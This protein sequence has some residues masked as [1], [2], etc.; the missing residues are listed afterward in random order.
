MKVV[1]LGT[2]AFA[3]P[4]LQRLLDSEHTVIAVVTQPDRPRGRGQRVRESAVKELARARGLPVLQPHRATDRVFLAEMTALAPDVGVVA[5]YGKLLPDDL[6]AI[7]HHGMINVHASLLPSYRG[8]API[9][10]AVLAGE[11]ETG[12]T[13][14]RLVHEMDAGPMLGRLA[15]PIGPDETSDAV[16]R[17]LATLGA[18]ALMRVVD[19]LAAGR[20]SEEE[21]DHRLATRAPRLTKADGIIDWTES[22]AA[23]HNRIRGLHPWPHASS[24]LN[25]RRYVILRSRTGGRPEIG[26][27]ASPPAAGEVLAAARDRLVVATGDDGALDILEI[28]PEGR[29]PQPVRDFLAGHV[30]VAGDVFGPGRS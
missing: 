3:V 26:P 22:S 6:L 5:A 23:V 19:D 28:Q 8:A 27:D 7:P 18:A 21:Q 2:P 12:V 30:L 15:R 16:E 25:G 17:D 24:H 20:A 29:R 4:T 10:R 1:F 13:I 11:T 9:Q 14:I